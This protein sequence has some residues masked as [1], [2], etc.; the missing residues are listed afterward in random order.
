M[1][2][3]YAGTRL[4]YFL[5]QVPPATVRK[6][7]I[8]EKHITVCGRNVFKSLCFAA[9]RQDDIAEGLEINPKCL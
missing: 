2:I 5:N 3:A 4:S 1:A 7:D 6:T 9:S 8:R